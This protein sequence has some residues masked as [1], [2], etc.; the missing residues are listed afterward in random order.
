ML[1]IFEKK[2]VQK[3]FYQVVYKEVKNGAKRVS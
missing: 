2:M 3:A 1:R